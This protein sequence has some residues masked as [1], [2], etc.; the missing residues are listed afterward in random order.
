MEIRRFEPRLT[1]IKDGKLYALVLDENGNELDNCFDRWE[2]VSYLNDYFVQRPNALTFYGLDKKN[3]LVRIMEERDYLIE[4]IYLSLEESANNSLDNL[5]F[6]PLHSRHDFDLPLLETKAYGK[7]MGVSF[8]RLYALRLS[9]GAY[10]IVGGMIKTTQAMQDSEEGLKMLERLKALSAF[11][12]RK[13]YTDSFDI[14]VL[15]I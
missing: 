8:L 6:L 3:A 4:K 11:L 9:D 12:I 1:C 5:V 14:G 10:I 15:L 13:G 7:N 2:D